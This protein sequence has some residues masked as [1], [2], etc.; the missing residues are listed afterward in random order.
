MHHLAES[1]K[2]A[3]YRI[4]GP[5]LGRVYQNPKP[6]HNL[7]QAF[8]IGDPSRALADGSEQP[9]LRTIRAGDTVL[10][11][12]GVM[13]PPFIALVRQVRLRGI[14]EPI[15]QSAQLSGVPTKGRPKATLLSPCLSILWGGIEW[16]L[17]PCARG[18][19]L[20]SPPSEGCRRPLLLKEATSSAAHASILWG[21]VMFLGC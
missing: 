17:P 19:R 20:E 4:N 15:R 10:V 7:S 11:D 2:V 21:G 1:T 9:F 12:A 18:S 13:D 6:N 14:G 8:Q 5:L 16:W 3:S